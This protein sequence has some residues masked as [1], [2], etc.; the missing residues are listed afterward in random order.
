MPTYDLKFTLESD[1]LD[2]LGVEALA[3]E[4]ATIVDQEH[5][6]S[7]EKFYVDQKEPVYEHVSSSTVTQGKG[8]TS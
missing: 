7:D 8:E 1:R 4:I 3:H 5:T 2:A 6:Y